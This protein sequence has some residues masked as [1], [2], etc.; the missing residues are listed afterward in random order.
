MKTRLY[1]FGV[2]FC[3]VKT[4]RFV[5]VQ[6]DVWH[7]DFVGAKDAV[8]AYAEKLLR[9]PDNESLISFPPIITEAIQNVQSNT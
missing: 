3:N 6:G 1:F 9:K 2:L 5:E 8:N 4:G 7:Y